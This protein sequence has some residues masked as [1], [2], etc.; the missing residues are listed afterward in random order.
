M[1]IVFLPIQPIPPSCAKSRSSNGAVSTTALPEIEG[2]WPRS[3]LSKPRACAV[4]HGDNLA[5]EHTELRCPAL[6]SASITS[7]WSS[8]LAVNDAHNNH[9]A[10]AREDAPRVFAVVRVPGHILH[11]GLVAG[12]EPVEKAMMSRCG[13]GR[14]DSDVIEAQP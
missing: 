14:C 10:N 11:T 5:R 9:R 4:P 1:S 2:S 3:H 13:N 7:G 6:L 12:L 8:F